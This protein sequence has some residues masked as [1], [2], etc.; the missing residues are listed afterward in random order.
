MEIKRFEI[1]PILD[2]IRVNEKIGFQITCIEVNNN[3]VYIGTQDSLLFCYKN[4]LDERRIKSK[5][6]NVNVQQP[7]SYKYLPYKK[8]VAQVRIASVLE[9][10]LCITDST[11]L[12]LNLSTFEMNNSIRM[13]NVYALCL[14]ENPISMDPFII[15]ICL[16]K[17]RAVSI[18]QLQSSETMVVLRDVQMQ[19]QPISVSMDG[20]FVCAASDN[21]YFMIDWQ[22]GTSQLLCSNEADN[23]SICKYVSKNEFLI[24]GLAHLG[25]FVKTSGISEHPPIDWGMGVQ[26]IAYSYPYILCLKKNV[27]SVI[28]VIDSKPKEE[29][30]F[31]NG[32]YIDNFDGKILIATNNSLFFMRRIPW[33]EQIDSLLEA[34]KSQEAND[35][36][37]TLY[38]SGLI[39]H[40]DMDYAKLVMVKSGL[41]ELLH[42]N[43][44]QSR[45]YL[46]ESE[47]DIEIFLNCFSIITDYVQLEPV[48]NLE[49]SQTILE[50]IKT[51][52]RNNPIKYVNYLI[53]YIEELIEQKKF[54]YTSNQSR[55]NT[56]LL[57][58]YMI[59][60]IEKNKNQIENLLQNN[61]KK[62]EFHSI[63]KYLKDNQHFHLLALMYSHQ[64]LY[65][66]KGIEIWIKLELK[67]L[68]DSN[69][70]GLKNIVQLLSKCQDSKLILK[71]IQFVLDHDQDMGS[72]VLIDN[73]KVDQ[74]ETFTILEPQQALNLLSPYR[75][76]IIIYLEYLV[77]ELRLKNSSHFCNQ[78]IL[79]YIEIISLQ[80][81]MEET[82]SVLCDSV[83]NKLRNLLQTSKQYDTNI[84]LKHLQRY[85]LNYES[86]YLYGR[87]GNHRLA[88]EI[89][90]DS[91]YSDYEQA[92]KHCQQYSLSNESDDPNGTK[93]FQTLLNVYLDLHKKN[94]PNSPLEKPLQDFLNHSNS[95][96]DLE[97][98][99]PLLP[100]EWSIQSLKR[101][102]S[103][104][105]RFKF[106]RKFQSSMGMVLA[107]SQRERTLQQR[108][109]LTRAKI[110]LDQ[111]SV[112][113]I[114][115]TKLYEAKFVWIPSTECYLHEYCYT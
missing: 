20:Y 8:A 111:N 100:I 31:N 81:E 41:F 102:I 97:Q 89:Y 87:M 11:F 86:A 21:N 57:I 70:D 43:Q 92:L 1:L 113:I 32:V 58:L 46:I 79:I 90:L 26:Q 62:F 33:E 110:R 67:Q 60:D 54:L 72:R 76:A 24:N 16:V 103:N 35:L 108:H 96:F 19:E 39:G 66:E 25:I 37:T 27:I 74:M 51:E 78:L 91:K 23:S 64:E 3:D 112:C 114:C 75:R 101:F 99:L 55:M 7:S 50:R 47:F 13:K 36:C 14:N 93:I 115:N 95:R 38:E 42:D 68:S 40:Q 9:L 5:D 73:T 65:I 17:K 49:F 109:S 4:I 106:N 84:V 83:L 44:E 15:E 48:E 98:T 59:D 94:G 56:C 2:S 53:C 28:S 30:Q 69:Y 22:Q 82:D 18:C 107:K 45:H 63:E 10:I 61:L 105:I 88:F 77:Y 29:L 71:H 104:Q 52:L 85:G 34:G 12:S 6:T 80:Q